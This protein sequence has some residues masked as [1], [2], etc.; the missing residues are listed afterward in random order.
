L[1]FQLLLLYGPAAIR[2]GFIGYLVARAVGAATPA[3]AVFVP[4]ILLTIAASQKKLLVMAFA[5]GATAAAVG[6]I[7]GAVFILGRH[8]LIDLQ[9]ASI[10]LTTFGLLNF[11]KIPKPFLILAT[12]M[13][14]LLL[15]KRLGH[16]VL[17]LVRE[18]FLD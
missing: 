13:V 8:S 17:T 12:G 11:K 14:S 5:Q 6:A 9:T 16:R 18:R 2:A 1:G 4:P 15:F 3:I 10:A 7:A